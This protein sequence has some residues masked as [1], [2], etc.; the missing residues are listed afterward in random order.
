MELLIDDETHSLPL[1]V[2]VVGFH[3]SSYKIGSGHMK[4]TRNSI[5]KV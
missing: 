4:L 5:Q 2:Y 1:C 3:K